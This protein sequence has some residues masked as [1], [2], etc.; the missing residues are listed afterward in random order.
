MVLHEGRWVEGFVTC[1]HRNGDGSWRASVR[2]TT[3]PGFTYVQVRP[4][5]EIRE[6]WGGELLGVGVVGADE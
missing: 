4:V 5:S 6:G 3:G 2:Y 1:W